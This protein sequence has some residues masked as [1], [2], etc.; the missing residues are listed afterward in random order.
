MQDPRD[1]IKNDAHKDIDMHSEWMSSVAKGIILEIGVRTGI[2][3][4]SF[5]IGIEERC[6]HLYSIDTN[7]L[8][9]QVFE[10]RPSWTFICGDSQKPETIITQIPSRLD[11]LFID[12]DHSYEGVKN[13]LS[14]YAPLVKSGGRIILHDVVSGYD[15]G[16]RKALDEFI[17]AT[18]YQLNIYKSWVGLGE[19]LIPQ[20]EWNGNRMR[21][22][23]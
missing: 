23:P 22:L 18:G 21:R 12:G 5:L 4:A 19:V 14:N 13:D 8:C 10:G 20:E 16:V 15:P 2:S 3:T 17:E 7:P 1:V 6:G 11:I 9:S